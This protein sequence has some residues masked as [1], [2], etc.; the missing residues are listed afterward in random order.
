M[1][2]IEEKELAGGPHRLILQD[3][4]ECSFTGVNEVLAF[5]ANEIVL[6]TQLGKLTIRGS[7]LHVKRLDL[8]KKEAQID[9]NVDSFQYAD[10]G[11][12]R[13]RKWFS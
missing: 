12:G 2:R 6:L 10:T 8:E 7:K 11:S 5:D 4:K 9:G 3:R 1:D 13:L